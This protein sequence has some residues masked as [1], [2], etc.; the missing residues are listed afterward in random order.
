MTDALLYQLLRFLN[1]RD[2]YCL[3]YLGAAL[4]FAL[5]IALWRRRGR[6]AVHPR[7][8][9][10]LLGTGRLWLHRSTV[11][12]AKLLL[13]HGLLLVTGYTVLVAS[14]EAWHIA[15]LSALGYL[16]EPHIAAPRWFA[17]SLTTVLQMLF[18]DLGYWALHFAFHRIPALWEVHKVHHSA[19]VLTPLTGWRMHPIEFVAFTNLS[20][21][22]MGAVHGAAGWL[23]GAS[24]APF[25]WMHVNVLLLL[26]L[27]TYFHLRH[28]GIWIA[29][30]GWLG[31]LVHSPA[32][33]QIHHSTDPSHFDRNMGYALS[34]FDWMFGTL[35][36]PEPR[37]RVA[38]GVP[39][40][41][42]HTGVLDTLI[43][44]LRNAAR[45]LNKPLLTPPPAA[46]LPAEHLS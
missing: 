7:L 39:E 14:S 32:H 13:M 18:L 2:S 8:I 27:A 29:A 37:G 23:F 30:T 5:V 43:R 21:F 46:P 12:D 15:T 41:A 35:H 6:R 36:I 31:R 33:H 3:L 4:L 26:F 24:A 34:L 45:V 44:P 10:N 17:G 1:P 11:L 28:S 22:A 16:G 19:E 40:D 9:L 25:E 38:L 20:G 42:P